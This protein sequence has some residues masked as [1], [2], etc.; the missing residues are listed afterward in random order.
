MSEITE[1]RTIEKEKVFVAPNW[2]LI[3]W[4]F[5]RHKLALVS[6]VILGL[7]YFCVIFADF[8][9]PS[10]PRKPDRDY[11]YVP[12]QRLRFFDTDGRFH[13]R[14]FVYDVVLELDQVTYR[15]YYRPDTA[16][17]YP[18]YFFARGDSYKL[19]G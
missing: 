3:W 18:I 14:P 13:L 9:A 19:F 6:L 11:I 12:P 1:I 10:D 7:F 2:K 8:I 4:K 15:R 16:R 17:R 5:S